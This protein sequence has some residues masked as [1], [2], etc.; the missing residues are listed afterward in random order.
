MSEQLSDLHGRRFS[1][2][3]LSVTDLC[4]FRCAYCLPNGYRKPANAA[5]P[6]SVAEIT[7]LVGAFAEL[8]TWK[9][10]VTGGEPTLRDDL[11]KIIRAVIG[12][13]G[14]RKVGVS[15]NGHRLKENARVFKLLGVS[16]L[17]VS[18]DSLDPVRFREITGRD[19]LP[20]ILEGIEVALGLGFSSVKVNAVLMKDLNDG[21]L[22]S[23]LDY[24]RERPIAARFIELM[25]TGTNQEHFTARHVRADDIVQSLL[26]R[27]W[28]AEE[29]NEA[30]GPAREFRHPAYAGR[31]GI[32]APYSKDFCASCNRLRV[33]SQG[34]LQLCL[35]GEG[36]HPLRHLLQSAGQR[37]E[38]KD[39]IRNLL[40]QKKIS[41][42]LKD[43]NYG[44]NQTF[45]TIGG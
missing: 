23:F 4:N 38:L 30:D 8:G 2:L 29:R 17:N 7:N 35:F 34:G 25:P 44:S 15:T 5:E 6:L 9:V 16:A 32:I 22:D 12:T 39:E 41:H 43:G 19:T 21:A 42:Y 13:P 33:S 45:S 14:I 26:E 11:P 31:I 24:V 3:R 27:G 1:Y 10:R 36:R 37:E 18:V 40:G 28:T 20:E